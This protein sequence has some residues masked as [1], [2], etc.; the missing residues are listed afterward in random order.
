MSAPDQE[1]FLIWHGEQNVCDKKKTKKK[2][3]TWRTAAAQ[4]TTVYTQAQVVL[5]SAAASSGNFDSL[6]NIGYSNQQLSKQTACL[7]HKHTQTGSG[8]RGVLS[9]LF[10]H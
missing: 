4:H 2:T 10:P 7:Q 1:T 8:F 3:Q 9:V 5:L 6:I